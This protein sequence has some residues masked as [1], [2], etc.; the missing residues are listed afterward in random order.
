MAQTF[1]FRKSWN[2]LL[3]SDGGGGLSKANAN[4]APAEFYVVAEADIVVKTMSIR[5]N[6]AAAMT[7]TGYGSGAAALANGIEMLLKDGA[8]AILTEWTVNNPIKTNQGWSD[9]CNEKSSLMYALSLSLK[10]YDAH[11]DFTNNGDS[12]GLFMKQGDKF[13][14]NIKDAMTAIV[15]QQYFFLQGEY[16]EKGTELGGEYLED[17]P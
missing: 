7:L 11:Y 17:R 4:G 1:T 13:I 8:D 12:K 16:I 10:G 3:T 6:E 15:D 14:I 5:I 2:A 9:F